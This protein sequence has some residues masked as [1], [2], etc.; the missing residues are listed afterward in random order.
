MLQ[1]C[2]TPYLLTPS[3]AHDNDPG[4]HGDYK[5]V[6]YYTN[7][8][9]YRPG[10]GKYTVDDIDPRLCTHVIYAFAKVINSEIQMVE[11]NDDQMYVPQ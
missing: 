9:Q 4:N 3:G 11:W 5:R 1:L 2:D 6:C 10:K 7:W 8:S